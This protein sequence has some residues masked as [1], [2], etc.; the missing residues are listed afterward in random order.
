[1]K[2]CVL[3]KEPLDLLEKWVVELFTP[4]PNKNL[5]INRWDDEAPLRPSE[6]GMLCFAKPVMDSRELN[7]YFPFLDEEELYMSQPS[8]YVGH[9][10]GHEGPGSIM[11]YIKAKGWANGLSA[12][13]YPVCPGTPGI[14]D[15]QI[16]LTEEGLKNYKEVVKVFF[17]YVSLL[18][19]ASPQQWIFDEQ[20]GIA[21]VGFKFKQKSPASRFT[22]KTS[23]L[24]QKPIPREWLLSGFSRL[25]QFDPALIQKTIDSL[26]T[27]NF[28]MTIISQRFPGDWDQK[29]KWY[30]TEYKVGKIPEDFMRELREAEASS[31]S[32]RLTAL[33]LPH[34]NNFIPTK[35]DVEKKDV[36][37]PATAPAVVRNDDLVRTWWK[38]DDTFWVPR[39]NLIISCKNPVLFASVENTV[40]TR[41]YA[42]LVRDALEEFSYD[43]ELAGLDYN[44]GLDSRGLCFD[45]SGYNDKLPVLLE[46]VLKTVRDLEI[47]DDRFDII[48][49]RL[50]RGYN[51]WELQSSYHQIGDYLYWLNSEN[52]FIIEEY[53]TEL[54][55][56]TSEALRF[57][58]PQL[59][60]QMHIEVYVHGNMYKEDA[61]QLTDM[62]QSILQPRLL[63]RTQWPTL[64]DPAN[65]NHCIE[66]WLYTGDRGDPLTRART[67]F[68]EQVMH[69]PAFDQL[70]TKEQL[71][72]IVFCGA[73]VFATTYGFRWLVQSER[74]PQYLEARVEAF[75]NSFGEILDKMSDA[76]FEN[77]KRSLVVRL[78]K[79]LEN[80]DSESS[81]HWNQISAEYYNFGAAQENA[82]HVKALTKEE[83]VEY[84]KKY[85]DV[86]SPTRAKLIVQL[87][88][89]GNA[90]SKAKIDALI[91]TNLSGETAET[92]E[93]VRSAIM[94]PELRGDAA[95]L[96]KYLGSDLKLAEDKIEAILAVAGDP[97]TEPK[98]TEEG[99]AVHGEEKEGDLTS[100]G[101]ENAAKQ[102]PTLI[103]DVRA[104]KASLVASAGARPAR[105]ITEY[106]E[107]NGKL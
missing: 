57:F 104:F 40:K 62:V 77:H 59:L 83:V 7:L 73:R 56:I 89:Q 90:K 20:K 71:G 72:Y 30:G 54:P 102:Q 6:L 15:C 78:L 100:N 10:I 11:S 51:N 49:E 4:V 16:R 101:T 21:E 98:E 97:A 17:Q 14:F 76:D 18:R 25:R 74:T 84:Y 67:L 64:K 69:E 58:K 95:A 106:E 1:M 28:R 44:V 70:R 38:K 103:T 75:I 41:L 13:T 85:I 2:L 80:L 19:E 42:D 43:A 66:Y 52:G 92:K 23:S 22:M 35:L 48:K 26:R 81:R 105:D 53:A 39:A 94:Q 63:P 24:M 47:K 68:L 60:G 3:G 50:K 107:M 93:A 36:K 8:R 91:N 45:L 31:A 96:R 37:E 82:E 79:K 86:A 46:Q 12:G 99:E 61:L 87:F 27:D 32:N 33:H 55:N 65:V 34:K 88:A 9:L 29:E 5:P